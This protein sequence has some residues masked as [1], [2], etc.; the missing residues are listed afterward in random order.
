M[1]WLRCCCTVYRMATE[2][3]AVYKV[4][5]RLAMKLIIVMNWKVQL[6]VFEFHAW[7]WLQACPPLSITTPEHSTQFKW[8]LIFGVKCAYESH[9]TSL[10]SKTSLKRSSYIHAEAQKK[11]RLHGNQTWGVQSGIDLSQAI[12]TYRDQRHRH[13]IRDR[14]TLW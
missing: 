1:F 4:S 5:S 6:V 11:Y 3:R 9:R 13:W 8:N 12:G 14:W 7:V 2:Q 10:K